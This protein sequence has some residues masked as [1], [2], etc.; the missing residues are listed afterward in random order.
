MEKRRKIYECIIKHRLYG[1]LFAENSELM[2]YNMLLKNDL[3]KLNDQ[4]KMKTWKTNMKQY[5]EKNLKL[6]AVF[7]N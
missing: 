7:T 3:Q 6:S 4:S 2:L 5:C 1:K